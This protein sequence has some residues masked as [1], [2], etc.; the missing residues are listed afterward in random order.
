[1]A[2]ILIKADLR[3]GKADLRSWAIRVAKRMNAKIMSTAP[4][5]SGVTRFV[6]GVEGAPEEAVRDGGAIVYQ[7]ERLSTIVTFAMEAL[8]SFSP[9]R[10]G[11]Y[12]R[13]HA[14]FINGTVA[15]DMSGYEPGDDVA[16]GNIKPYSRKIEIG[17][18]TMR[19]P[20][21]D[22]V[23]RQARAEIMRR[24]GN[25]ISVEFTYRTISVGQG[26]SEDRYPVLVFRPI[27]AVPMRRRRRR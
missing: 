13:A 2:R 20:G 27:G 6:D 17:K 10:S 8:E 15:A 12:K 21:T 19:L 1:V 3:K 26:D 16:I 22:Q 7:Y 23:Y 18:M 5:P 24:Y 25:Q 11:A 9:V 4:E 14:L